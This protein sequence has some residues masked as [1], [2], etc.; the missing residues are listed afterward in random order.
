MKTNQQLNEYQ[1]ADLNGRIKVINKL[2]PKQYR[3]K[4]QPLEATTDL[5]L[6]GYTNNKEVYYV[7]ECKD[8]K[9]ESNKYETLF[10]DIKKYYSIIA[11]A[12]EEGRIPLYINTFTDG[13]A[14]IFNLNNIPTP[15]K[16]RIERNETTVEDNGKKNTF[17]YL[18]TLNNAIVI[19]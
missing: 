17:V 4:Q 12:E 16:K 9:F 8:R 15:E 7:A 1:Q 3:I 14:L 5:Y 6:T 11:E 13:K 10:C 2:N 18:L 19:P